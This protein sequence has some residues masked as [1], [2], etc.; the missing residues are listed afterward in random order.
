MRVVAGE[1]ENKKQIF[2]IQD[3]LKKE[4]NFRNGLDTKLVINH[5]YFSITLN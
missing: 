4:Q 5:I 1:M 3:I 2:K